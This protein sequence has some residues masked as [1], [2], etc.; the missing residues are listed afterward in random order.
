MST[1]NATLWPPL[2]TPPP[3]NESENGGTFAQPTAP[4]SQL[5]ENQEPP[6]ATVQKM[7]WT[8][9]PPQPNPTKYAS[10]WASTI[11]TLNTFKI[12]NRQFGTPTNSAI[13]TSNLPTEADPDGKVVFAPP[14]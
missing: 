2:Q 1:Y 11:Q 6:S 7:N 3:T 5:P 4:P 8:A 9:T 13:N 14:K 12:A 10:P